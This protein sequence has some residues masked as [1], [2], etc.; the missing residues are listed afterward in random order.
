MKHN[1]SATAN[2]AAVT[3]G[4][5][6]VVCRLLVGLFPGLMFAAA[7]SL[8][9]GMALTQVGTWNLSLGNFLLGLLT[10]MVSA[11]FVG[12]IFAI[13]YNSLAKK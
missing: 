8:L 13:T 2:A 9:H 12:Y 11:W 3:I 7:Q 10:S 1:V 6:Y 4:I 5:F